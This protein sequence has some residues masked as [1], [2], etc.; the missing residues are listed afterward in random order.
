MPVTM[1]L[2]E[3]FVCQRTILTILCGC[4]I[5]AT[6]CVS[7]RELDCIE[8]A[9]RWW[10]VSGWDGAL[11]TPKTYIV[12]PMT[13]LDFCYSH[14]TVGFVLVGDCSLFVSNADFLKTLTLI[15]AT[16]IAENEVHV[17]VDIFILLTD[18]AAC[19]V[20]QCIWCLSSYIPE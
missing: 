3:C 1:L 20:L 18:D 2:N 9:G 11:P 6:T 5:T 8:A 13:L 15:E 19:L 12:T 4:C 16:L 17:H 7:P 10:F 14:D